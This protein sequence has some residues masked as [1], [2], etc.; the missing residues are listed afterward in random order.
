MTPDDA[1][2]VLI[3][4]TVY[5]LMALWAMDPHREPR[6][7][8]PLWPAREGMMGTRQSLL[9]C[10]GPRSASRACRGSLLWGRTLFGA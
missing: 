6:V 2:W 7:G 4:T 9:L 1:Y 10:P 8:A 5:L 3:V